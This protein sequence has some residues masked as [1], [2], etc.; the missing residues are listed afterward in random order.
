MKAT[1]ASRVRPET[2]EVVQALFGTEDQEYSDNNSALYNAQ[3]HLQK[4]FTKACKEETETNGRPWEWGPLFR[5]TR[6]MHHLTLFVGELRSD[7]LNHNNPDTEVVTESIIVFRELI[8]DEDI[9]EGLSDKDIRD[10]LV[11]AVP[12]LMRVVLAMREEGNGKLTADNLHADI[13]DIMLKGFKKNNI[14]PE[15]AAPA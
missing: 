12:D 3:R 11:D 8:L 7:V 2:T 10:G 13:L 4:E 1:W 15:R 14:I 6:Q 5:Y 9:W